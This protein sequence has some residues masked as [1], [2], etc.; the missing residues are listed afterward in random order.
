[1][2]KNL[3]N[4]TT[5]TTQGCIKAVPTA[6]ETPKACYARIAAQVVDNESQDAVS[7]SIFDHIF[8][9]SDFRSCHTIRG[10]IPVVIRGQAIV[11]LVAWERRPHVKFSVSALVPGM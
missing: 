6:R 1:L 8:S 3:W 5:N 11:L 7:E 10:I 4:G 9:L 2:Y